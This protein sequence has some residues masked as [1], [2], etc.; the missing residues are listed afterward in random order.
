MPPEAFICQHFSG[1]SINVQVTHR[2]QINDVIFD[3]GTCQPFRPAEDHRV[4]VTLAPIN[5]SFAFDL[6][7]DALEAD[8][9]DA[10]R[11]RNTRQ[12]RDG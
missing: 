9:H 8:D 4:A 3:I 5:D 6:T 1:L 10:K 11:L 12:D 2:Q 7:I